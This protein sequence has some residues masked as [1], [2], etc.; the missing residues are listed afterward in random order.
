MLTNKKAKE[1][2]GKVQLI[3]GVNLCGKMR[4]SLGSKRNIMNDK[5]IQTIT[6]AFGA[7]E[8]IE[9]QVLNKVAEQ[10][11]SRGRQSAA[12]K[13]EAPKTFASKIFDYHKFGYRRITIERPLRLSARITDDAIAGLRFAP[14]PFNAVMRWIYDEFGSD[15][16][17]TLAE[18]EANIRTKIKADF[19]ELKEKQVKEVLSA[20]LWQFQIG[21]M[22]KAKALQADIGAEQ[23][24]DFNT[25][26]VTL[27]AALKTT[28]TALDAK[29][30]KQFLNAITFKN[31]EAEPVV[32]K[33]LKEEVQP[34]YGAFEYKGKVVEFQQDGDL[35]D[36]ENVPLNPSVSTTTL[37]ETYFNRE[38]APPCARCLDQ[39]RQVRRQ[40]R[41]DRHC[42]LR[43]SL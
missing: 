21:L 27:K 7:F 9:P 20:T 15:C 3:N 43:D 8:A 14:K 26:E 18:N 37:I 36:N 1:R 24:D 28:G 13:A 5:D 22:T 19:K 12:T 32:K 33:V 4:K 17:Q 41:R 25:F 31:P 42:R 34:L 10:K 30:K 29:E 11:S 6:R 2:K 39:C 23:S 16:H 38:V 35:R 40:R